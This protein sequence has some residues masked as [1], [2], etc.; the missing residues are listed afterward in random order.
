MKGQKHRRLLKGRS[1]EQRISGRVGTWRSDHPLISPPRNVLHVCAVD[2]FVT[3]NGASTTSNAC[4]PLTSNDP[5]LRITVVLGDGVSVRETAADS[6]EGTANRAR[7][8][9]AA[10]WG[11][12]TGRVVIPSRSGLVLH[13]SGELSQDVGWQLSVVVGLRNVVT[14]LGRVITIIDHG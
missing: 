3:P 7:P 9:T 5:I 8:T 12:L 10:R 1:H 4:A 11:E 2:E 6:T 14:K 13:L